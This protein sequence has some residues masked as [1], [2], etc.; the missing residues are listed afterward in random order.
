MSKGIELLSKKI[1]NRLLVV[2]RIEAPEKF[3]DEE[4]G[5]LKQYHPTDIDFDTKGLPQEAFWYIPMNREAG[6]YTNVRFGKRYMPIQKLYAYYVYLDGFGPKGKFDIEDTTEPAELPLNT[7]EGITLL[8]KYLEQFKIQ[9]DKQDDTLPSQDEKIKYKK[10][11]KVLQ[12]TVETARNFLHE[13][14]NN[15]KF[16]EIESHVKDLDKKFPNKRTEVQRINNRIK[17]LQKSRM[18]FEDAYYQLKGE[19][20]RIK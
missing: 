7:E 13:T 20:S 4:I 9:E 17:K 6:Y 10:E 3:T 16:S 18:D 8:L 2:D 15:F 19:I 14:G 12:K 5:I 1:S 11:L